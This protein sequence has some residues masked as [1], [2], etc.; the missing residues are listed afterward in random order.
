MYQLN[1]G[2]HSIPSFKVRSVGRTDKG[3]HAKEQIV[4]FDIKIQN[5]DGINSLHTCS[6]S[7]FDIH[8]ND[9]QSNDKN[10]EMP[11]KKK[12][13]QTRNIIN[14]P[15][16]GHLFY[17]VAN[18]CE[19]YDCTD[20][21]HKKS[22]KLLLKSFNSYLPNDVAV[23][24]IKK[25]R[26]HFQPR[27]EA[28]CKTYTYRIRYEHLN[29]N[30]DTQIYPGG[31]HAIRSPFDDRFTWT[32][33]WPLDS[34][35]MKEVCNYLSGKHDYSNFV[36]KKERMK[37]SNEMELQINLDMKIEIEEEISIRLATIRFLSKNGFRRSMVR[38]LTG[39][40]VD[41]SRNKFESETKKK[42]ILKSIFSCE[43]P[44]MDTN[45]SVS[46]FIHASPACGL[47]LEKVDFLTDIAS[48]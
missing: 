43:D 47:C 23:R 10:N 16:Y 42:E 30:D 44:N 28:S 2:R 17:H 32:C 34:K 31:V 36:H 29:S 21:I 26:T 19:Q 40:I 24:S 12:V 35:I 37:K 22:S 18:P 1:V 7:N 45:D 3:V 41:I 20:N 4:C 25:V 15:N 38:N 9:M 48:T 6:N 8:G 27:Q 5:I 39:F 13:K 11:K 33:P 46:T 14:K